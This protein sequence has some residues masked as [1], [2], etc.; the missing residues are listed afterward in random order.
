MKCCEYCPRR[1]IH[2]TRLESLNRDKQSILLDTFVSYEENEVLW[3]LPQKLYSKHFIFCPRRYIHNT[4]L[5]SLNRDK[6]SILLDTFVSY[7]ENEVLWILPQKQYSKHFIF[8]IAD[9]WAEYAGVLNNTRV[10][11]PASLKVLCLIGPICKLGR[12]W[13]VVNT[14]PED[15]FTTLG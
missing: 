14:A 7:E 13:S 15:I 12:K 9:E 2:N 6:Q 10:E 8:F 11:R 5:E 3:I 1:Y 4:R